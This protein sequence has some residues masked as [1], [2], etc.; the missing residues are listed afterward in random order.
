MSRACAAEGGPNPDF[1][2]ALRDAERQDAEQADAGNQHANAPN[3]A[4]TTAYSRG[5]ARLAITRSSI[6]ITES[7]ASVRRLLA[8][9]AAESRHVGGGI[10]CR[11]DDEDR[12]EVAQAPGASCLNDA[13]ISGCSGAS[14]L[15]CRMSSTT[16]TTSQSACSLR[17]TH[18][19]GARPA[20]AGMWNTDR[21]IAE[22]LSR[23]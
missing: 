11:S 15:S 20:P 8:H 13:K 4:S 21:M 1:A 17:E 2:R 18:S 19:T 9:E 7:S 23:E 6:V 16:P 22:I 14:T 12:I 5:F 3:P 10:R